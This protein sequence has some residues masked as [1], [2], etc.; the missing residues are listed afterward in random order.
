ML[1]HL[2]APVDGLKENIDSL[3]L[4]VKT[5]KENGHDLARDW[6]EIAYEEEMSKTTSSSESVWQ[7]IIQSNLEAIAKADVLIADITY[8]NTAI[9]YQIA[10]AI[11][12]KKPVLL[13]LRKGR[14]VSPFTWNIPSTFLKKVEYTPENVGEEIMPFLKENDITTKDMRFNFFIDRQ[15]YNYLRWAAFKTGKTKAE[16]LRELVQREIND[17]EI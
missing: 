16:I 10:T 3:R 4:I 2:I 8:D 13:T 11:H 14:E 1:V 5:V 15:I 6:L 9:G 7:E 12:Q 17:K